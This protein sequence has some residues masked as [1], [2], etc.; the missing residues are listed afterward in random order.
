MIVVLSRDAY[1]T[2]TDEV[3]DWIETL[4]GD[5]VRL[6]G[7]DLTGVEPYALS[8]EDGA[9]DAVFHLAGR[10]VRRRDVRAVWFRRWHSLRHFDTPGVHE[11]GL[12][13]SVRHHLG[14]ETRALT[15]ALYFLFGHARWL[16][17]PAEA[18]PGK[19]RMLQLAAQAGL[20]VPATLVT[21]RRD[22]LRAFVERHG[23]VITKCASDV[24]V[25]R[26]AGESWGMYTA[27]LTLDDVDAAPE[28]FFPTL[29]Q[30]RLEKRWEV[31]TF[32]LD[33]QV[34]SMAI[35]SQG[36]AQTEVD[37]R[38]Y[39]VKRPN[40]NVPYRLP[41][42]VVEALARFMELAGLGTGSVDFVRTAD[43][44]HVF[45]EVNPGG[46]FGMVSQ[47]CNYFLEKKV[48]EHLI[49]GDRPDADSV[50]WRDS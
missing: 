28:V 14:R 13:G 11:P 15:D 5:A 47:P 43:G 12:L 16:T 3:L 7:E 31:R 44:R 30:E 22:Q 37:F 46:Q 21:N 48:A 50:E 9:L 6:N 17:S 49:R 36:D 2:T 10:P 40:R 26:H 20:P 35:F 27:E 41:P 18:R 25:F 24:E 42:E 8:L 33:G 39:N 1:E 32:W 38:R 34:H 23:R 29:V 19:L 4:G 45:L